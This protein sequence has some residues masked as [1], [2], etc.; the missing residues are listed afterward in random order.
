MKKTK[1]I[2]TL[3][4]VS[5]SE[6][7]LTK[8]YENWINV[9]RFNFSHAKPDH[10]KI[11]ADRIKNLNSKWITQLSLLLDTKWPEIRTWE[12]K[13]KI[14]FSP[15][16]KTKIFV[17]NSKV[18][19][20]TIFCDYEYLIE[21]LNIWEEIIIDS[22][23]CKAIV[24]EKHND[25]LLV[26][27][28]N[29]CE[30]WSK[31]HIN[32]PW[33]KLKLPWITQKDKEDILFWIQND[34]DFIAMSFVRNKE[35]I[36][37]LR[38]FLKENNAS[39]IKIISKVENQEAIDNLEEIIKYSDW[40]M[41]ARW[42]L[43]IEV[44]IEKLPYYQNKIVSLCKE[45]WKFFIIATHLLETMIENLFPTRA[46]VSD[47]YN[48]VLD[49]AD[50]L[51][52]SWETTIWKYPLESVKI[53]TSV[54]KEAEK[55]IKNQ[56]KDFSNDWLNSRDI[57]KKVLIK[58]WMSIWEELNAKAIVIL[59]KSWLLASLSAAFRPNIPVFAFT[60]NSHSL[61]YMNVLYSV[62]PFLLQNWTENHFSNLDQAIKILQEKNYI[63]KNDKII[64]ITDIQKDSK[65][66]PI[67]EL[68]EV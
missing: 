34:F 29:N 44:P 7:M 2:A 16:D 68:I 26:E 40:I 67:I 39:H 3:W 19:E 17:D 11:I 54:I 25:F 56:H 36:L 13:E 23:L 63:S 62:K 45:S 64:A 66:N 38:N 20:N 58:N 28:Q 14:K 15:W 43:W 61:N 27:I 46:E 9:I 12:V 33:V 35:N 42:D 55:N 10:S 6:E 21:D 4:P 53:M 24:L 65:E 51:M 50:S 32:L 49:W 41:V 1:I 30:I 8:M 37:E 18:E 59:T 22:W 47:I 60:N 5:E 52:L 31:R 48:S 57:E